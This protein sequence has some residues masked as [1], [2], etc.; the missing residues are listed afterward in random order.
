M[1]IR[2][3]CQHCRET[4]GQATVATREMNLLEPCCD[5]AKREI[6]HLQAHYTR[7]TW[8]FGKWKVHKIDI[9]GNTIDDGENFVEPSFYDNE[10]H[11]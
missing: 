10:L 11:R 3:I 5:E 6:R 9:V 4:I 2:I 7:A 8:Q 1:A